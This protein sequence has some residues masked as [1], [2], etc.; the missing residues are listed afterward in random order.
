MSLTF[1][2]PLLTLPLVPRISLLFS[3]KI[4]SHLD[5]CFQF[6]P[7]SQRFFSSPTRNFWVFPLCTQDRHNNKLITMAVNSSLKYAGYPWHCELNLNLL[8]QPTSSFLLFLLQEPIGCFHLL[9]ILDTFFFTG[10]L[11]GIFCSISLTADVF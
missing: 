2:F 5:L 3:T 1:A 4:L 6:F 7:I 9:N 11:P 8:V 10:F